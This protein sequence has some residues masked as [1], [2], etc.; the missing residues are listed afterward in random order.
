MSEGFCRYEND[1]IAIL[2]ATLINS[3]ELLCPTNL[4]ASL[5]RRGPLQLSVS[6]GDA[7]S[8]SVTVT[9]VADLPRVL[10]LKHPNMLMSGYRTS[11]VLA[12]TSLDA[13]GTQV[14]VMIDGNS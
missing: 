6:R 3:N 11:F 1:E 10:S 8:E 13:L 4:P 14:T 9:F 2:N 12:G 7:W 5:M